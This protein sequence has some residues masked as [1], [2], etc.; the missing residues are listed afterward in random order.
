MIHSIGID[1]VEITRFLNVIALGPR[2]ERIFSRAEINYCQSAELPQ[3]QAERFAVRF[4][5]REAIWK[6]LSQYEPHHTI[7][8][9][10][11]CK[12]IT[13]T[14]KPN[15]APEIHIDWQPL[16]KYLPHPFHPN[17]AIHLS[18]THTK[19][20]ATAFVILSD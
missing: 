6:A 19:T 10:T 5:A 17:F 2:L 16:Q 14:R 4:A 12:S 9:F 18:L 8:F 1:S 13:I 11:F 15:G 7:P 3:L 20:I